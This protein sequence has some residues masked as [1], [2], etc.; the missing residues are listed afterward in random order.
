VIPAGS[1]D[2][3]F[4][5][6]C[7]RMYY[8]TP[9]TYR[10]ETCSSALQGSTSPCSKGGKEADAKNFDSFVPASCQPKGHRLGGVLETI[11]RKPAE[12]RQ[13]L[14]EPIFTSEAFRFSA[15]LLLKWSEGWGR[16]A[17]PPSHE[18]RVEATGPWL[19]AFPLEFGKPHHVDD[20]R[21]S[22]KW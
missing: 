4:S 6:T 1:K 15:R 7:T 5:R 16:W 3:A 9:P 13:H 10:K 8:T 2:S 14:V 12:L 19:M 20:G 22:R 18:V 11:G 17:C 21:N